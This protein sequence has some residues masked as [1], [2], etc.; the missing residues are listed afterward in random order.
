MDHAQ[1]SLS[2]AASAKDSIASWHTLA[3]VF[4]IGLHTIKELRIYFFQIQGCKFLRTKSII[5]SSRFMGPAH[6]LPFADSATH[7][8]HSPLYLTTPI[9]LLSVGRDIKTLAEREWALRKAGYRVHSLTA[10]SFMSERAPWGDSITLFCHTL[11]P[12]ECIFLAAHL[13][14]YSPGRRLILLTHGERNRLESV[15]FHAT[16]RSEDG[17]DTL[18]NEINRLVSAA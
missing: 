8:G 4:N 3:L 18:C 6:V 16:V 11:G 9:S 2:P 10:E 1:N 12:E 14:R 5:D 17:L 13:R 7:R 15:L